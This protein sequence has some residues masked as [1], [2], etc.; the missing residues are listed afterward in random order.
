MVALQPFCGEGLECHAGNILWE[1]YGRETPESGSAGYPRPPT[2]RKGVGV[3]P[4]QEVT[5]PKASVAKVSVTDCEA[6]VS[7]RVLQR[8]SA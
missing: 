4:V 5:N 7:F 3:V 1:A 8:P 2:N 6:L